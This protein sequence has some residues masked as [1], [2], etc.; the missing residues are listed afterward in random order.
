MLA[1]VAHEKLGVKGGGLLILPCGLSVCS[2]PGWG[3]GTP[4]H[5]GE[6]ARAAQ[7]ANGAMVSASQSRK[8][9]ARISQR[10]ALGV[11]PSAG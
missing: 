2:L 6:G 1:N 3:L 11:T 10:A 8:R 5:V 7:G 4:G 9:A